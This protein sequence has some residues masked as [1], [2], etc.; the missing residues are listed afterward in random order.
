MNI[1]SIVILVNIF[2]TI[3]TIAGYIYLSIKMSRELYRPKDWLT[4]LRWRIFIAV[5]LIVLTL[6]PGL[7]YQVL[8]LY[9]VDS[10]DVRNIVT[11][12]SRVNSLGALLVLFSVFSYRKKD[13]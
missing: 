4:S 13:R 7:M 6:V 12:T 5:F 8:R 10:E 1:T 9:G 2:A 11:I 3:L